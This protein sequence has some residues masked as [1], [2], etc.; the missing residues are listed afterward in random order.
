[1]VLLELC[2]GE[3]ARLWQLLEESDVLRGKNFVRND[4]QH[5]SKHAVSTNEKDWSKG[6]LLEVSIP[7]DSRVLSDS[8]E[9]VVFHYQLY[10]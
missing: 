10:G 3:S 1:M 4:F 7:F 9:G 5:V 8:A 6:L 2:G